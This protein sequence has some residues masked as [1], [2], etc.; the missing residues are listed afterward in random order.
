MQKKKEE[1]KNGETCSLKEKNI[2]EKNTKIR[3]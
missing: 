1:A 2:V 3:D